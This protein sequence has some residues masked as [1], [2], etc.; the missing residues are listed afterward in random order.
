MSTK[1]VMPQEQAP[2]LGDWLEDAACR[3]VDPNVFYG[4]VDAYALEICARCPVRRQ[5]LAYAMELEDLDPR[6]G[7]GVWA[8]LSGSQR[9]QLRASRRQNDRRKQP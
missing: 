5:C 7:H 6:G 4:H 1:Q 8:G 2:R 3:G 9:N